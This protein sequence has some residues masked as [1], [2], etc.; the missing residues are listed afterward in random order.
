[1][2]LHYIYE[3]LAAGRYRVGMIESRVS[4]SLIVLTVKRDSMQLHLHMVLAVARP[5]VHNPLFFVDAQD[6]A[7]VKRMRR[8]SRQELAA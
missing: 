3:I 4:E 1:M 8:E 6:G 5:I 7:D 2:S